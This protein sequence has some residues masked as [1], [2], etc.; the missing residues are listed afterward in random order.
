MLDVWEH[1]MSLGLASVPPS[2]R[3]WPGRV[4]WDVPSAKDFLHDYME[5]GVRLRKEER[6]T[7]AL[8]VFDHILEVGRPS[9]PSPLYHALDCAF[10][11][12]RAGA[13]VR[14]A[15]QHARY[16][17]G[18]VAF[19]RLLGR[20]ALDQPEQLHEDVEE[21]VGAHP[22]FGALIARKRK[23]AHYEV[24]PTLSGEA[25]FA[26]EYWNAQGRYWEAVPEAVAL[27]REAHVRRRQRSYRR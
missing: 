5:V 15:T 7:D 2:L 9:S 6:W 13:V 26:K 17:D 22:E 23:R 1:A 10:R 24:G 20:W 19:A 25:D 8:W 3:D 12:G 16:P 18:Y 11:A 4:D 21:A 14:L 27:V